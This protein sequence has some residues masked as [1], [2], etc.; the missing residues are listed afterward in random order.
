MRSL[1]IPVGVRTLGALA[2]LLAAPLHGQTRADKPDMPR[3]YY[4]AEFEPTVPGAIRPY[5]ERVESTLKPFGGRFIARGGTLAALEGP[6]PKGVVVI[7]EFDS[8]E[9]AQAWYRSPAYEALKP[10]RQR[11]GKS[12]VYI[13]E[14]VPAVNG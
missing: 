14:G 10:I 8:L 11:A 3:A 13:M 4:V 9:R 7:I 5:S 1:A 12:R 2:I 6:A